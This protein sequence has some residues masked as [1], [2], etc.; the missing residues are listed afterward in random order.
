MRGETGGNWYIVEGVCVLG[1]WAIDRIR[2]DVVEVRVLCWEVRVVGV[3]GWQRRG[4]DVAVAT[5]VIPSALLPKVVECCRFL[6][7]S[8]T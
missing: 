8:L 2:S 3:N 7:S 4:S 6:N 1:T 5:S